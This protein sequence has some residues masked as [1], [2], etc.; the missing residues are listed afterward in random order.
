M[1]SSRDIKLSSLVEEPLEQVDGNE[2][3]SARGS[4]K[5]RK[6]SKLPVEEIKENHKK[7]KGHVR[8]KT[9]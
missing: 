2:I 1:V 4:N 5:A 3:L 7:R 8:S 6:T 9:K